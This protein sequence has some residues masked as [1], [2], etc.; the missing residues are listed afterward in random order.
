MCVQD[1]LSDPSFL[2]LL[3]RAFGW[4]PLVLVDD[5]VGST[6]I[7]KSSVLPKASKKLDKHQLHATATQSSSTADSKTV[8]AP[9]VS[10][11]VEVEEFVST[12]VDAEVEVEEDEEEGPVVCEA[13]GSDETGLGQT[14]TAAPKVHTPPEDDAAVVA[15]A[16]VK[17][18]PV[19]EVAEQAEVLGFV[20]KLYRECN[21][22]EFR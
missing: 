3:D 16:R 11:E 13:P 20:K 6:N 5:I 8:N 18:N 12:E 21:C 19:E 10:T 7:T 15:A 4:K 22:T 2:Q 9:V 17:I 1:S 14:P